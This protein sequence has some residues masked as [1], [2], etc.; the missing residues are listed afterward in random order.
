MKLPKRTLADV[1]AFPEKWKTVVDWEAF[2]HGKGNLMVEMEA[3]KKA[4]LLHIVPGLKRG[5]GEGQPEALNDEI[6]EVSKGDLLQ[7]AVAESEHLSDTELVSTVSEL[8]ALVSI[9]IYTEL[10]Y[11]PGWKSVTNTTNIKPTTE[12]AEIDNSDVTHFHD[13]VSDMVLLVFYC[14]ICVGDRGSRQY[15]FSLII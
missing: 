7:Q 9:F 2:F 4:G 5:L 8:L 15:Y 1:P 6:K 10:L 11:K 12:W 14:L 3:L 13:I